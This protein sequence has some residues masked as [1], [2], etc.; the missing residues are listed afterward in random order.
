MCMSSMPAS[1]TAA[2][3]NDLNPNIGRTSCLLFD[4]V[5]EVFDLT[6]LDARLSVGWA[7]TPVDQL[8]SWS[9]GL[10]EADAVSDEP[11]SW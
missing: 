2:N 9:P 10:S 8:N 6:D 1:V 3:R 5:V 11:A 4:D 7:P